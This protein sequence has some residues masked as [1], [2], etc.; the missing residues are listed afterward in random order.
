MSRFLKKREFL[1]TS[2]V[3]RANNKVMI[4]W[5][6]KPGVA[7]GLVYIDHTNKIQVAYLPITRTQ[8]GSM[9]FWRGELPVGTIL[10][11]RPIT[12][13]KVKYFE[14]TPTGLKYLGGP[15]AVEYIRNQLIG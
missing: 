13:G 6:S 15:E 7:L 4:E 8:N 12:S 1:P 2:D 11:Q 14:V 10:V 9:V 3:S 5:E